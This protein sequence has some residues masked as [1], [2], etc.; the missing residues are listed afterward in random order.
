VLKWFAYELKWNKLTSKV[1]KA[2]EKSYD[3]YEF[4]LVNSTNYMDFVI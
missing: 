1:P 3:N 4:R 2:W